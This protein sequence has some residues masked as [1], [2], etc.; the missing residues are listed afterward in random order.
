M[1]EKA[2]AGFYFD[3][4]R[5]PQDRMSRKRQILTIVRERF[6][7]YLIIAAGNLILAP[8]QHQGSTSAVHKPLMAIASNS[9]E[10]KTQLLRPS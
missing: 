3:A 8:G 2:Y 9:V 4:G 7:A 5:P 6:A 1:D 10:L